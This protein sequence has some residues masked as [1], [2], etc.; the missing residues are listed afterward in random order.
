MLIFGGEKLVGA[1]FYA[2]C[3]YGVESKE[4]LWDNFGTFWRQLW[5]NLDTTLRHRRPFFTIWK[6]WKSSCL[7]MA[8]IQTEGRTAHPRAVNDRQSPELF[9]NCHASPAFNI[10]CSLEKVLQVRGEEQLGWRQVRGPQNGGGSRPGGGTIGTLWCN[11][12]LLFGW[13]NI[14]D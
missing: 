1:N 7:W 6:S 14:D 9:R 8:I 3:N 13:W 10:Q 12:S 5:G 4:R 11:N 2:F